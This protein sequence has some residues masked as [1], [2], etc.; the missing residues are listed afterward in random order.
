M[1]AQARPCQAR[2]RR[3]AYSGLVAQRLI[4]GRVRR[5][6]ISRLHLPASLRSTGITRFH[7]YYGGSD[8]RAGGVLVAYSTWHTSPCRR[9]GL[10]TSCVPPSRLSV[11][12]HL[13]APTIALA[14]S[15]SVLGFPLAR[16]WAS[17]VPRGLAS[18]RGR[19]EFVILR[20][21]RSPP[22]A[23][24][25]ASRSAQLP[26]ASGRSVLL[27]W[28]CTSLTKHTHGRTGVR[29]NAPHCVTIIDE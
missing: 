24:H 15:I 7:R 13:A 1:S 10:S 8:S 3:C 11:S 22:V 16:V 27:G 4:P 2:P 14:P 5:S 6:A 9:A 17:P 23:P 12:N 18:R 25:A 20:I 21:A 26:L 28:T 29:G 19:I